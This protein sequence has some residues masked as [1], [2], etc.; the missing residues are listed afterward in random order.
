MLQ[1][2]TI[3]CVQFYLSDVLELKE[4]KFSSGTRL[5][6]ELNKRF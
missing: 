1:C 2:H 3:K 5:K 6:S 4:T